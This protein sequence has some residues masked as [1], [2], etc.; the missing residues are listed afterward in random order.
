MSLASKATLLGTIVGVA[1]IIASVHWAQ[2]AE[3]AAMHAGVVRDLEN[4]R[5]KK[6]RQADFEMQRRLE[7]EYKKLQT[8]H[9]STDG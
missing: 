6:E 9:D 2:T 1:G 8:V 5:I 4:Q 3:K 7:E